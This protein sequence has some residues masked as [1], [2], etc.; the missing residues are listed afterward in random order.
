[1]SSAI[2]ILP[3]YTH[4]DYCNWE[5]R[6]EVIEGIPFAMSPAP[7]PQHQLVGANIIYELSTPIKKSG[8]GNCKVYQ[9]ID[10]KI[11]EDTIVQPDA[12]IVCGAIA[13]SFLDFPPAL[14]VEI[15]SPSTAFK[16]RHVKFSLYEK[17]GIKYFLLVDTDRKVMEVNSIIDKKYQLSNYPEDHPFQFVLE[18]DCK[19]KVHLNDIW[20]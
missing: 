4:E 16:D 7:V 10:V 6:W 14:V 18:D 17:M 1:M 9:F 5:G 3:H 13:K 12:L 8:C 19:I 20:G 11:E 2:K 15:L